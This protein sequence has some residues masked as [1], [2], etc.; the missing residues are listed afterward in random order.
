MLTRRLVLLFTLIAS[1]AA[2]SLAFSS[3]AFAGDGTG[4]VECGQGNPNPGCDV[5]AGTGGEGGESTGGSNGGG[6]SSGDGKCRNPAG[7]EIP[8][9]RD[10]GWAGADGCYYQPTD[11]P[12]SVIDALGGQPAGDGGWYL[13]VCYNDDGTTTSGLG[14]P[15]WMPG[16]P[17]VVSPEVLARQ[18]RDRLNLPSVVIRLNP[19]GNQ[20][21]NLPVWLSLDRSSW[22]SQS[23]TASAGA[24]SV[25]ATARPKQATWSMGDG[26]SRTCE[27]PGTTWTSGTDP[28]AESPDCGYVYGRGG[29]FTITVTV[30]W[31]VTWA[32]AGQT[33]TIDGLQTQAALPAAVQESQALVTS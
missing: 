6:G 10:G 5:G 24:V 1:L 21:V 7:K 3:P 33:G 20:L 4:G 8:C 26:G 29:A 27:G 31:E 2:T 25:T 12:A 13:K 28:R 16:A 23:A 9:Q 14:G 11:P 17:P 22:K 19:P 30:T 18:A 32:G 15:V